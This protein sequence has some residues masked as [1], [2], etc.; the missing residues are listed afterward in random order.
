[1]YW[2]N[3][4]DTPCPPWQ[5]LRTQRRIVNTCLRAALAPPPMPSPAYV[6]RP[7]SQTRLHPA[8]LPQPTAPLPLQRCSRA[9][10]TDAPCQVS[11]VPPLPRGIVRRHG[12]SMHVRSPRTRRTRRSKHVV[13][14]PLCTMRQHCT[15]GHDVPNGLPSFPVPAAPPNTMHQL[16]T[17]RPNS[18]PYT[19]IGRPAAYAPSVRNRAPRPVTVTVAGNWALLPAA[20]NRAIRHSTSTTGIRRQPLTKPLATPRN[21]SRAS[22]RT[23]SARDGPGAVALR[24]VLAGQQG[25]HV[26]HAVTAARA[27]HLAHQHGSLLDV[28]ALRGGRKAGAQTQGHT[29]RAVWGFCGVWGS[30][31]CGVCGALCRV[32]Y[33]GCGVLCFSGL[34][35]VWA[36]SMGG[37]RCHAKWQR[38]RSRMGVGNR[39]VRKA[40]RP[41]RNTP[42]CSCTAASGALK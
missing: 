21:V 34:C 15:T 24:V 30:V 31:P 18:Q 2:F 1:M 35:A 37:M 27:P 32:G 26:E 41:H 29:G 9:T 12:T 33:C 8:P 5:H 17:Q 39:V 28:L 22:C 13:M 7:S 10:A 14:P 23:R 4:V 16:P 40:P 42:T 19:T 25:V 3:V 6:G 11:Q 20:A 38:Q 36:F